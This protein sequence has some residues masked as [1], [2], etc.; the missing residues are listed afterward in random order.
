MRINFYGHTPLFRGRR[1]DRNAVSQLKQ[2][3]A[4]A[5]TEPNQRRINNAIENLQQYSDK[6]NIEFLL[7]VGEHLRYGTGIQTGKRVKN[8]WQE[9]LKTAA[10]KAVSS[11]PLLQE[12]YMPEIQRVFYTQKPLTEEEK[13]ILG[14]KK[15]ILE[16]ADLDSLKDTK[17]ENIRALER[18]MEYFI[19]SSEIPTAQKLYVLKR[20]D[21]MMSPDLK[22]I[23]S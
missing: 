9:K 21:Y 16:R 20:L 6:E 12:K 19:S 22:S 18:N 3:N 2:D 10:E 23:R 7:D 15:S 17:N 5:L 14:Y 11:N 1:E 13:E 4:Y 8:D